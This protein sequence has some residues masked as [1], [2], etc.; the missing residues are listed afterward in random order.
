[1]V[2][3]TA[4]GEM[5]AQTEAARNCLCPWCASA[6]M[7]SRVVRVAA[8]FLF[9]DHTQ[10]TEDAPGSFDDGDADFGTVGDGLS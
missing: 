8:A 5:S 2:V 7:D 4:W 3:T 1:M 9:D 10:G 6:A